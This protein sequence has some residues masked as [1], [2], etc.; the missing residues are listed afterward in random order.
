MRQAFDPMNI[1]YGAEV[2][3]VTQ[4][5]KSEKTWQVDHGQVQSLKQI[6]GQFQV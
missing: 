6:I 4:P 1:V 5:W 2:A 3:G